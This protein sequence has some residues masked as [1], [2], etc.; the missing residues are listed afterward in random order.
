MLQRLGQHRE[1]GRLAPQLLPVL[2]LD[3]AVQVGQ[4]LLDGLEI[5]VTPVADRL[6]VAVGAV[7]LALQALPGREAEEFR[8]LA[9]QVDAGLVLDLVLCAA[10]GR[11]AT[12][13][14]T[15]SA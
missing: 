2:G 5:R 4:V 8:R 13:A 6:D 10:T 14:S 12:P 3:D 7:E 11:V 15:N 9:Q 1:A